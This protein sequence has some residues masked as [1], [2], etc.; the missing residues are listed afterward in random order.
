MKLENNWQHNTLENL[1]KRKIDNPDYKSFTILRCAELCSTPLNEFSIED[2][3]IMIGQQIGLDYLIPLAI[4][5]L[6]KDLFAEGDY[7][8]GDL[9]KNV[10]L[11]DTAFW[12]NTK[13]HWQV[14]NQLIKNSREEIAKAKFETVA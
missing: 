8:E 13:E 7:F 9:L 1:Q 5:I 10:L 3:R 4:E 11:V 6:K 2:L 14:L 12:D